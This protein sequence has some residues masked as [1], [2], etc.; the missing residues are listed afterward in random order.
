MTTCCVFDSIQNEI[1]SEP[2]VHNGM[3]R[4]G[5]YW[6]RAF[7]DWHVHDGTWAWW[8]EKMKTNEY[9]DRLL[10]CMLIE[11]VSLQH[12]GLWVLNEYKSLV[13]FHVIKLNNEL[14][15]FTSREIIEWYATYFLSYQ[16][17]DEAN[18]EA[19][20]HNHPYNTNSFI[21]LCLHLN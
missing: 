13:S 2:K 10:N 1:Q 19:I 4:E 18:L 17:N 9:F 20:Y 14:W 15:C 21:N 12:M 11:L 8:D 3:V 7:D 6:L 16:S 5:Y